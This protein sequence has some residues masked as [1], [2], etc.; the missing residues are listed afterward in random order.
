M[1]EI[2]EGRILIGGASV[3]LP[4]GMFLT[5]ASGNYSGITFTDK[6]KTFY[7]ELTPV[8]KTY[9]IKNVFPLFFKKGNIEK[10]SQNGL[11]GYYIIRR[12][13]RKAY[14]GIFFKNENFENNESLKVTIVVNKHNLS[15]DSIM[16]CSEIT[17]FFCDICEE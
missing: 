16:N 13:K 11:K 2:K 15:I 1:F 10:I 7:L 8:K 12:K 14:Y 5:N 17:C 4:E 3:K 6:N 9:K